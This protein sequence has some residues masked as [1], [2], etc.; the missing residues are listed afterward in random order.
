MKRRLNNRERTL[1]AA[2]VLV[3]FLVLNGFAWREFSSR[4]K[5]LNTSIAQLQD[6]STS[7]Q[8]WLKDRSTWDKRMKWLDANMPYTDSAGRSQGQLL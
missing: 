1:L 4:R 8:I 5:A 3:I 7:N 6:Q 2:C